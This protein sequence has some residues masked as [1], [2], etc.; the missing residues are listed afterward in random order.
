MHTLIASIPPVNHSQGI[1]GHGEGVEYNGIT[2]YYPLAGKHIP[3]NKVVALKHEGNF[4]HRIHG[5]KQYLIVCYDGQENLVLVDTVVSG[6]IQK[7]LRRY[8]GLPLIIDALELVNKVRTDVQEAL[9]KVPDCVQC[10]GKV[11]LLDELQPRDTC[12]T[13]FCN[14][15][16]QDKKK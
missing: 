5:D 7:E 2:Y 9:D 13:C 14:V 4:C 3:K 1:E 11:L 8:K 6:S 15:L 16:V 12:F 10:G